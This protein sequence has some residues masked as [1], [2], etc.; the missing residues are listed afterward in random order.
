[1]TARESR[2]VR[3]IRIHVHLRGADVALASSMGPAEIWYFQ[4][5]NDLPPAD[6]LPGFFIRVSPLSALIRVFTTRADTIE[7]P[8]PL[9]A[10]FLPIA[11]ML[12][13]AARVARLATGKPRRTVFYALE[14]NAPHQALFGNSRVPRFARRMFV[15]TLARIVSTLVDRVVFGSPS[16]QVA[17]DSMRS[18]KVAEAIMLTEL[19]ARPEDLVENHLAAHSALFVGALEF[20][21]G[22]EPLLRAW[23]SVEMSLPDATITI[24]GSGPLEADV[25][26]WAGAKP[27]RRSLLGQ[28]THSDLDVHY[29]NADVLIAPSVR[30]GRWREQIGLQL[31]EALTAG[32]TVVA[33]DETGLA[34][35]LAEH[36]HQVV[37]STHL[38]ELLPTAVQAA[39][40]APLDRRSVRL[41]LPRID[42]RVAA[43][44]WLHR[45]SKTDC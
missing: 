12:M 43:D 44:Q 22:V 29:K 1:M 24:V 40:V 31:R 7:I 18:F 30:D 42:Q 2:S 19:P 39:L 27:E 45:D 9:W 28:V 13:I 41:S 26:Q 5:H 23:E 34:G 33:S 8:E 37:D 14:N 38:A 36:G 25:R 21:K 16:A 11:L 20:R 17:Y 3:S 15:S 10:R 32:L 35:W 6:Q 4:P